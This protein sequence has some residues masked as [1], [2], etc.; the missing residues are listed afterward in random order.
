MLLIDLIAFL[1][2]ALC[3]LLFTRSVR[4][5]AVA[6]GRI[7]TPSAGR[8]LH[9]LAVPRLGGIAVWLAF[10]VV[11]GVAAAVPKLL[12]LAPLVLPGTM[13]GLL[14]PA[15]VVFLVGLYDDLRE[16][17]PYSKFAIQSVA[18]VLVYLGGFGIHRM[19]LFSS[20]H[21]LPMVIGLP[22]TVLWVVLITN[23]F[24]LI[25]GLD[26]LAAGSALFSTLVVFVV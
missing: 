1:V 4:D 18:A 25:D 24:N 9:R 22:L 3:S 8:H 7:D 13:L 14:G 12:G 23:A 17:D 19:D 2:S 11:V 6:R 15:L 16:L 26:G 10:M 20:S 21:T 5:F